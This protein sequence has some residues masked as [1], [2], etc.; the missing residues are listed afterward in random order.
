MVCTRSSTV[1][2][3]RIRPWKRSSIAKPCSFS[4]ANTVLIAAGACV[5][6]VFSVATTTGSACERFATSAV[7]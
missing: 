4:S 2:C 3:T 6:I 7:M 1:E 5:L